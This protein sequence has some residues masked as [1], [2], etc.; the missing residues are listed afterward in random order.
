M[1]LA[2][3]IRTSMSGP[4]RNLCG[5]VDVPA[6]PAAVIDDRR[7]RSAH[8]RVSGTQRVSSYLGPYALQKFAKARTLW[9]SE[10]TPRS[11]PCCLGA[12]TEAVLDG[13]AQAALV[14]LGSGFALSTGIKGQ[15]ARLPAA[16]R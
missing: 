15:A 3:V 8:C 13:T 1:T 2:K 4:S 12:K 11:V 9:R 14:M 5:N 10:T 7:H 6:N 16:T